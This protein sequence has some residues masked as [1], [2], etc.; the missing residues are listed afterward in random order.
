MEARRRLR[1]A[2]DSQDLVRVRL[3]PKH[4]DRLSGFVLGIG[5]EWAL[6]SLTMDGGYFDGY[7]VFRLKD[8]DHVRNDSGFEG[9]FARTQP[10]WPPIAPPVD[11]D[12]TIGVVTSLASSS[13]LIGIEKA[14]QR[15]AICIGTLL[16]AGRKW[17]WLHE[18]RPDGTW[19]ARPRRHKTRRIANV[20]IDTH[21]LTAL[22]ETADDQPVLGLQFL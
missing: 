9:R 18:V 4:A 13:R 20:Q 21:Y 10:Q 8:I 1:E 19:E 5:D 12:S 16:R 22:N 7:M 14:G 2:L 17:T 6:L 11:L 3:L 15:S